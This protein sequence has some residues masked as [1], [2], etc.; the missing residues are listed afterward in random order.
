MAHIPVPSSR[1]GITGLLAFKPE[2]GR[3]F[4][5]FVEELMR[6][7][8]SLSPGERELIAARVSAG[9]ECAFC[10]RSHAAAAQH[11]LGVDGGRIAAACVDPP[12]EDRMG[13]LLTLADQVRIGGGAVTAADIARARAAGADDEQVHDTVLV[14]AAF[15]LA[16]RYVDGLGADTPDDPE[17]YDRAGRG[18][19]EG[20]YL[21]L[22]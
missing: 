9:N 15:C 6:G 8:S 4:L 2:L 21:G 16:N 7:P 22:R 3:K 19:A 14:A 13:A 12:A 18:L 1:P 10:T 17:Y 5:A 11:A 20:G